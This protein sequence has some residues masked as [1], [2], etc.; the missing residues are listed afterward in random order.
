MQVCQRNDEKWVR[1]AA[2]VVLGRLCRDEGGA[3]RQ[4][5]QSEGT[6]AALGGPGSGVASEIFT[7]VSLLEEASRRPSGLN[8][9]PVTPMLCPRSVRTSSPLAVSQSFTLKSSLPEASRRPLGLKATQVAP[10]LWPFRVNSARPSVA[11]QSFTVR[12]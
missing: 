7:V 2:C 4:T 10:R 8:A 12:S 9:T 6:F 3:S 5:H 1:E 11:S